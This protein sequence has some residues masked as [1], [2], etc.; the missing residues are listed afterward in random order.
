MEKTE[1]AQEVQP[2]RVHR[3][4]GVRHFQ[5][6]LSFFGLMVA[7]ILR[8]NLS[9]A[10]VGMATSKDNKVDMTSAT[11]ALVISSF[12]WGYGLLQIVFSTYGRQGRAVKLFAF[13]NFGAGI[14]S[15]MIP[16]AAK[17]FGI[18]GICLMRFLSGL[19]Q[20]C[21]YP[22]LHNAMVRWAIPREKDMMMC[23][24]QSGL[25]FGNV[26]CL[27]ISGYLGYYYDWPSIFYASGVLGIVWGIFHAAVGSESPETCSRI[28]HEEREYMKQSFQAANKEIN[29][30]RSAVPWKEIIFSGPV[31]A[32]AVT[33]WCNYWTGWTL[34]TLT[35]TYISSVLGFN[36]QDDGLLSALPSLCSCIFSLLLSVI[37]GII[38]KKTNIPDKFLRPFWNSVGMYG[39]CAS[40]LILA[41]APV[42]VT[43]AVT[44]L[45]I[46]SAIGATIS[47]GFGINTMDLSP[48]FAGVLLSIVNSMGNSASLLGPLISTYLIKDST[49]LYQ[50]RVVFVIAAMLS[51]IGNSV[52]IFW[53]SVEKQHWDEGRRL[54]S[55]A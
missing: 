51:F 12:F 45:T 28:T 37:S 20:G 11:K 32:L 15:M 38:R 54:T 10:V 1:L 18:A 52:F 17:N 23:F 44:L 9:V 42:T 22:N 16:F 5:A 24:V 39:T 47:L 43:L 19:V 48:N 53:G 34:S 6:A 55:E 14:L 3:G 31:I 21:I 50:W 40:L 4:L 27:S 46:S 33:A 49:D 29:Q 36:L 30:I 13:G 26:V 8:T 2:G 25:P 7:Y 41:F 35:P